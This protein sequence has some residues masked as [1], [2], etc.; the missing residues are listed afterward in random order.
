MSVQS[1]VADNVSRRSEAALDILMY[2]HMVDKV[3][4]SAG[5]VLGEADR[6]MD[7]ALDTMHTVNVVDQSTD[8]VLD[9]MHV[10]NVEHHVFQKTCWGL[11]DFLRSSQ[12]VEDF[13]LALGSPSRI[14]QQQFTTVE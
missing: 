7:V 6:S 9:T 13:V 14:Y 11:G 8:V 10:M 1:R 5:T 4:R 3:N 12:N 2:D